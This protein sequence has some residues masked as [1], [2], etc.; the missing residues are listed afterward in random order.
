MKT[1]TG[2]LSFPSSDKNHP[3]VLEVYNQDSVFGSYYHMRVPFLITLEYCSGI[4]DSDYLNYF[5]ASQGKAYCNTHSAASYLPYYLNRPLHQHDFYELMFVLDGEIIQRIEDREF[6]YQA[7][8]CCLLNRNLRH[9]EKFTGEAMVLF[10]NFSTE[11]IQEILHSCETAL[12]QQENEI[13]E[14]DIFTFLSG[15]MQTPG[16]KSYLDFFPNIHNTHVLS[17]L[18]KLADS[19]I[20][21]LLF[22]SFGSTY[23]VKALLCSVFHLLSAK[24]QYHTTQVTLDSAADFLLFCRVSHVLE[25]TD[26][27]INRQELGNRFHYTG[28]YLNR[29]VKKYSGMSLFDYSMT[30]C[31]EKAK[32]LLAHTDATISSIAEELKFTNRTHFYNLF[33][34]DCG[35]TPREYRK[36]HKK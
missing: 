10:I 15:D 3:S 7:G 24:Q 6:S 4:S 13:K 22:P 18:H 25:D 9:A 23:L 14:S 19:F 17:E 29:I 31:M 12:F 30:F 2:E 20:R 33:K 16:K 28:D 11:F 32:Y 5:T 34:K 27:R 21:T 26:G 1:I 8:T 36:A 35:M